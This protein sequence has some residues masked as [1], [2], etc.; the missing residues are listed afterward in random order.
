MFF[1]FFAFTLLSTF[2]PSFLSSTALLCFPY[3][4]LNYLPVVKTYVSHHHLLGTGHMALERDG[5]AKCGVVADV[6]Y[7]RCKGGW[8]DGACGL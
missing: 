1:S 7:C 3:Y 6:V 2:F 5:Q 8:M 4:L